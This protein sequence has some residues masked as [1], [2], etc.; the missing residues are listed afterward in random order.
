MSAM[1]DV[2]HLHKEYRET[3]AVGD[4]SFSVDEGEIF[5]IL[6]PNADFHAGGSPQGWAFT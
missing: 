2:R 1:I 5:G 3:V 6:G 4:V